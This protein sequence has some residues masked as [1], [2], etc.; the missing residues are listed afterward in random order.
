VYGEEY[1]TITDVIILPDATSCVILG[2]RR[3]V[4]EICALSESYAACI[5]NSLLK[6][7][8]NLSVPCSSAKKSKKIPKKR[9]FLHQDVL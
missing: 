6:F 7:W 5:C 8:E 2:F 9:R 1:C 4:K 3:E